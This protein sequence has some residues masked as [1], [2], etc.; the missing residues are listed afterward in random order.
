MKYFLGLT[1]IPAIILTLTVPKA[2]SAGFACC[3]LHASVLLGLF[4]NPED[5]GDIYL[6]NIG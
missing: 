2:T 5:G 6:R 1:Q 4:F 3:L